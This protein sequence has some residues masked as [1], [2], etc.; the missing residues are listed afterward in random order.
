MEGSRPDKFQFPAD[1]A[2]NHFVPYIFLNKTR[3]F[4]QKS[5]DPCFVLFFSYYLHPFRQ[6]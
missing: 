3:V 1:I 2:A 6:G 5:E 4:R